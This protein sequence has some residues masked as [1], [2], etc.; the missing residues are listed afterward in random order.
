MSERVSG[1]FLDLDFRSDAK[2]RRMRKVFGGASIEWFLGVVQRIYHERGRAHREFI[3]DDLRD[4]ECAEPET[5]L[6]FVTTN[7]VDLFYFDGDFLCSKRVDEDLQGVS[8]RREK[9][10]EEKRNQKKLRRERA[11]S[12]KNPSGIRTDSETDSEEEEEHEQ[13]QEEE[14]EP[15]EEQE[16]ES[17]APDAGAAPVPDSA[18]N[19]PPE[20]EPDPPPAVLEPPDEY[21]Q[22]AERELLRPT[23]SEAWENSNAFMC[24]GRRPLQRFPQLFM[25]A[26]ELADV[27]REWEGAGLTAADLELGCKKVLGRL[28]TWKQMGKRIDTAPVFNWLTG[29]VKDEIVQSRT[30]DNWKRK[31]EERRGANVN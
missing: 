28:R 15:E 6:E 11:D 16:E 21:L 4:L 19:A 9:W 2:V 7:P 22:A 3:L 30:K 14:Q 1:F 17:S 24:A 18:R 26:D 13:E 10:R 23:G 27:F 25:T 12:A 20:P 5:F 8:E 29:F 31:S